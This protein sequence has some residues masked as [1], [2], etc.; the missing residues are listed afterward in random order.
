[1]A[2]ILDLLS[3]SWRDVCTSEFNLLRTTESGTSRLYSQHR[4][5]QNRS[6]TPESANRSS[7]IQQQYMPTHLEVP[8]HN[9]MLVDVT[10]A[11]Q[12]L[13]DAVTRRKIETGE[14]HISQPTTAG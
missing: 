3:A 4:A 9:V 13:I 5:E 14:R 1:M 12:D 7:D 11:L 6:G 2:L 8:V 10:D